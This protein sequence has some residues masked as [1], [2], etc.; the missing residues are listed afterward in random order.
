MRPL[1]IGVLSVLLS[2]SVQAA[3]FTVTMDEDAVNGACTPELCSIR[4]A[5]IA[6]N[7]NKD[8]DTIVIPAGVYRIKLYDPDDTAQSGDYDILHNVSIVG[9]GLANVFIQG[10]Q[11]SRVF[12]VMNGARVSISGVT[13]SDGYSDLGA[14]IYVSGGA[15]VDLKNVRVGGNSA[16]SGGAGI[17]LDSSG[18]SV[19]TDSLI[20][21][22]I[23][24]GDVAQPLTNGG[25]ILIKA[26]SL[27]IKRSII[28]ENEATHAGGG[29]KVT[30]ETTLVE[31]DHSS[32]SKN[33]AS[34]GAGI[35][36]ELG[37][38]TIENSDLTSNLATGSGGAI[39]V[40]KDVTVKS[41]TIYGNEAGSF[42][43]GIMLQ[44]SGTLTL[45]NVT[46]AGN[47][48]FEGG[49]IYN[50]VDGAN[51]VRNTIIAGNIATN[52][53]AGSNIHGKLT[54]GGNNLFILDDKSNVPLQESDKIADN[55]SAGFAPIVLSEKAGQSYLPL[56]GLSLA[57]N[58]GS[59][60]APELLFDQL[61]RS[62][63]GVCD[64]GAAEA[65]CGDNVFQSKIGEQCDDGN[66]ID[67]D[68]CLNSCKTAKCGDGV[69]QAGVEVCDDG[70]AVNDDDCPNSCK[71]PTC[72]DAIAQKKNNETCDDGNTENADACLN[73]CV[74][75][76]C[77][78][79]IVQKDVE[80]CDDGNVKDGDK[81]SAV[82]KIEKAAEAPASPGGD[83]SNL[84][85]PSGG[86]E[87]GGDVKKEPEDKKAP[88][89]M[90]SSPPNE[91]VKPTPAA[92]AGDGDGGG[93]S[94]LR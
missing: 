66:T 54:S 24:L 32:I 50:N 9:S 40:Y 69:V 29:I 62:W 23:A 34:A 36:S 58:N 8:S 75:A 26:G 57:I 21:K 87:P 16:V 88:V 94:L 83:G 43:G 80:E 65:V 67:T 31:I 71:S 73:S 27:S 59:C 6:A 52:A 74:L 37:K 42:G 89:D 35:E 15:M 64:I 11:K 92:P 76:K 56:L 4:D 68:A 18:G 48:A 19:I 55:A 3:T 44:P 70:N 49:G 93:C 61:D 20:W 25:G 86:K 85:P 60:V 7:A 41:S 13:I 30:G 2:A 10:M 45:L 17:Y 63:V 79:G 82:C 5:V 51:T 81:C 84:K 91:G 14:G 28:S 72:G 47:V 22:N 39:E 77:G 53:G 38:I 1:L 33:K 46:L 90:P 12:D 78:D